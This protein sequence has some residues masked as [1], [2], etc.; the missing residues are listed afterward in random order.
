MNLT[1]RPRG[2]SKSVISRVIS[3]L[4]GVTLIISL[5]IIIDFQSPG[6]P[7]RLI[8][9]PRSAQIRQPS[10]VRCQLFM[11][12]ASAQSDVGL[13][14]E[15]GCLGRSMYSLAL[16]FRGTAAVPQVFSKVLFVLRRL[17]THRGEG[18][19]TLVL[20]ASKEP[21]IQRFFWSSCDSLS[22][23]PGRCKLSHCA[24]H[25]EGSSGLSAA[26]PLSLAEMHAL[27]CTTRVGV[28]S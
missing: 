9:S 18:R 23:D 8:L 4:N 12:D 14:I 16:D 19:T 25:R 24:R 5:L 3:T 6:P 28:H 21:E 27:Q 2:L 10:S 1:W 11:A 13:G 17:V 22:I 26:V 20:G 15:S 7:S